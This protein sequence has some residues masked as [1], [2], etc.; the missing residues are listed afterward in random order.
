MKDHNKFIK[1][2]FEEH[3][4]LF[5]ESNSYMKEKLIK[6]YNLNNKQEVAIL[7]RRIKNAFKKYVDSGKMTEEEFKDTLSIMVKKN[8][9][10][11]YDNF[12]KIARAIDIGLY[13]DELKIIRERVE[14][15]KIDWGS[16]DIWK[17]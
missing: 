8:L 7:H 16:E 12:E 3:K 4:F 10:F 2:F 11:T 6:G 14:I 1:D 5:E 15:R 13:D 9:F 17:F